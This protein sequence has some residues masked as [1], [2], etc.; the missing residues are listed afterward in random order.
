MI[1][2]WCEK[3]QRETPHKEIGWGNYKG[4]MHQY[5]SCEESNC[6]NEK[7]I[8]VGVQ[9]YKGVFVQEKLP[10]DKNPVKASL[11]QKLLKIFSTKD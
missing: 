5:Y 9:I 6:Y 8:A 3:C 1:N 10:L 4:A 2:L 7:V 11:F